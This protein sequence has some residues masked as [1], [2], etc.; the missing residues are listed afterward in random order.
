MKATIGTRGHV[1]YNERYYNEEVRQIIYEQ[2]HVLLEMHDSIR[3]MENL[4]EPEVLDKVDE[5]IQIIDESGSK[6]EIFGKMEEIY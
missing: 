3:K 1:H 2:Q 4:I 6:R 5:M